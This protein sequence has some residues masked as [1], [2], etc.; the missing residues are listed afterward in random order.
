MV[1]S[2][3]WSSYYSITVKKDQLLLRNRLCRHPACD[4]TAQEMWH[5]AFILGQLG[6]N[7][8]R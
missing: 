6:L 4:F 5:A 1:S 8:Y 3:D 7:R 2:V